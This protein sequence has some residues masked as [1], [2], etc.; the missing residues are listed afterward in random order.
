MATLQK[1][2]IDPA[3]ASSEVQG[4]FPRVAA[5]SPCAAACRR[6]R[7]ASPGGRRLAPARGQAANGLGHARR[8]RIGPVPAAC[9]P[10]TAGRDDRRARDRPRR[11]CWLSAGP[12]RTA[13]GP[14]RACPRRQRSPSRRRGCSPSFSFRD[15]RA[16]LALANGLL[17][18]LALPA[19][20]APA[21]RR[22][23]ALRAA[24][25]GARA[26]G[27]RARTGRSARAACRAPRSC[28]SSFAVLVVVAGRSHVEVGPQGDEPHYLMVAESLLR[29][30]DVSLERDYAEGRY[31]AFHDAPLAPHFRVRGRGGADLLAPRRGALGPDPAGLGARRLR[32]RHRLHGAP[33]GARR[34]ARCASGS[35]SSTGREALAEGAG[36]LA[37]ADPAARALRRPRVHRGPAALAAVARPAAGAT[38]RSPARWDALAVGLAAAALPWLNVRYALLAAVVVAHALVACSRAAE[39]RRGA[40]AVRARRRRDSSSTTTRSTASGTRAASTAAPRARSRRRCARACRGCSSTRS[41]AS[42]S[43]RPS[44]PSA[45]PGL[46]QLYRRDRALALAV[47]AA[48]VAVALVAGSWHMWR[49]GFNPPGRFLVPVAPLG[50]RGGGPRPRDSAGSRRA[51]RS[52]PASR[53]SRAWRARPSRGSSTATATGP[54]RSSASSRAPGSGRRSCR[55]TCSRIRIATGSRPSGR[56]RSSPRCRGA[57]ATASAGPPGGRVPRSRWP[58]R[59]PP[60]PSRTGAPTIATPSASSAAAAR[61]CTFRRLGVGPA[62]ARWGTDALGW[63]PLYEPHRHP[64]GAEVGRR[65]LPARRPLPPLRRGREPRRRAA[66]R[67]R[68]HPIV[69]WRPS[70]SSDPEPFRA[71]SRPISPSCRETEP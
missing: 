39:A 49:G 5:P 57:R 18:P 19:H 20:G 42:S 28:R 15:V 54:R 6:R 67:S 63:G 22:P 38:R 50:A 48:A 58:R 34:A 10:T 30:H 51:R 46:V 16:R 23:R 62:A 45:L 26:R 21:R 43:T 41:S 1:M 24:A 14:A 59:R 61:W 47:V 65:L 8:T 35:A 44:S 70:G 32:G 69:R 52:S 60:P 53:S 9:F 4:L 29:D 71:G 25:R 37:V 2:L 56:S 36:W 40:R 12:P 33:R 3:P 64:G 17:L 13:S 11:A 66:G 7:A 27:A 68:S 31:A 55:R